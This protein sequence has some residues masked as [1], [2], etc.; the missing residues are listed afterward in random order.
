MIPATDLIT[1]TFGKKYINEFG[2][3]KKFEAALHAI[4]AGIEAGKIYNQEFQDAKSYVSGGCEH[5]QH[6]SS[7]GA[8]GRGQ[9]FGDCRDNIGY[10]FG[11]N[12]AAKMSRELKKLGKRFPE[13][14]TT[15][16][17]NYVVTLDQIDAIWKWLQSVKPIIV[18]GRKPNENK[19]EAQIAAELS[20]TGVC[21][22]C[23][24]RQKL[25]EG[26]LVMH[27]YEMSEYNH[28]GYRVGRS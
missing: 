14:F 4:Q 11:M 2:N 22:I 20:N 7:D 15:G 28:S 12:Q 18:K 10:A 16:I 6:I 26:R 17:E 5:A 25:N 27:G 1:T 19:T 3:G 9:R 13:L 24:H 21:A 23:N 8:R